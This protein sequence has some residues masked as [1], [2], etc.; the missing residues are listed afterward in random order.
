MVQRPYHQIVAAVI[1]REGDVLLVQQQG[2]S[3]PNP[4]WA[5]PGGVVEE[6]ELLTEALVREV[7]EETGLTIKTP[8]QLAYIVQLDNPVDGYHS[9]TFVFEISE[10]DGVLHPADPDNLILHVGFVPLTEAMVR[11]ET[12]PWRAMREPMIAYLSNEV[13]LGSLWLYRAQPNREDKLITRVKGC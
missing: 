9:I 3:A 6:R 8:G 1:R 10:W 12:L 4:S 13:G 2:P 11:L 5:L 7:R